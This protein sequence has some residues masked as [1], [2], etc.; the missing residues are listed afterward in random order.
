MTAKGSLMTSTTESAPKSATQ[1]TPEHDTPEH[2]T[3][4]EYAAEESTVAELRRIDFTGTLWFGAAIIAVGVPLAGLLSQGWRPADLPGAAEIAWWV[5]A[6]LTVIGIAG[7]AWSGCP[8]LAWPV[9]I[10]ERQKSIT[11]RGGVALYLAGTVISL[12]AIL[13]VPAVAH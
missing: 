6:A 4:E 8:V 9:P 12:I 7:F 11:I 5:G 1:D 10:A 2:D 13:A 3:A